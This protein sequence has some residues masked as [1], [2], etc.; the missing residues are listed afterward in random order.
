MG[1]PRHTS[2]QLSRALREEGVFFAV[3]PRE[4]RDKARHAPRSFKFTHTATETYHPK[5]TKGE[6][7]THC[8]FFRAR[9]AGTRGCRRETRPL[10][11]VHTRARWRETEG[12][13]G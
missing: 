2:L 13:A 9:S 6:P 8:L 10:G 11:A 4:K 5:G 7:H 12:P 3:Q 1:F